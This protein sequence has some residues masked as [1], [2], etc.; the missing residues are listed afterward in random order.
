[1]LILDSDREQETDPLN[2]TKDRIIE[3]IGALGGMAWV[4]NGRVI[5][6]YLPVK[7]LTSR[8][9]K[10]PMSPNKFSQLMPA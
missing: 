8:Y 5:E 4:T 2:T 1:M 9:N 3:E 10:E 7:A 6:N